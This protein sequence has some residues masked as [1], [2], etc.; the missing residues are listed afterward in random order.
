LK[1]LSALFILLICLLLNSVH[2]SVTP[3]DSTAAKSFTSKVLLNTL[4]TSNPAEIQRLT[5]KKLNFIERI[6]LK[7][8][9]K[10]L[11]KQAAAENGE[12]TEKQKKQGKLSMMFGIPSLVFLFI[13]YL[14]ILAI[15]GAIAALVLGLKSI[16]GNSN[17]QGMIGV[18][19]G[20][21]TL[22]LVVIAIIL[23]AAFFASWN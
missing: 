23:V 5:G 16:K 11:L 22:F 20:S 9:Q 8:F 15:P 21:A 12:P 6:S 14:N 1:K 2:A 13:P 19:T 3:G 4:L 7:L 10:K 18:I 17:T